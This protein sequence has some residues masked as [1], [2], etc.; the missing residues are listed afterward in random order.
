MTS[1]LSIRVEVKLVL[2][3]RQGLN[4]ANLRCEGREGSFT[5]E[6][7]FRRENAAVKLKR[8]S[9]T[10]AEVSLFVKGQRVAFVVFMERIVR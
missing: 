8:L 4:L 2:C 9:V 3:G 6:D 10:T 7:R 5:G 1:M